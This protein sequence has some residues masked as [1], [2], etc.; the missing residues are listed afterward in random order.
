MPGGGTVEVRE[1]GD[2]GALST[3]AILDD[4]E[5]AAL[6]NYSVEYAQYVEFPTAYSGSPPPFEPIFDWVDRKWNDLGSGIKTDDDGEEMTKEEVARR[7]QF[8]I[9]KNGTDGVY[10]GSR[11]VEKGEANAPSVLASFE[12]SGDPEANQKALA[13][14]ANG[15]FRESQRII[16]EEA[17]DTGNLLQSGS[18]E[19]FESA[20]DLPESGEQ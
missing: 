14:V 10:F 12:G 18:I 20:D 19:W 11:A 1:E 2:K 6:I 13:E 16:R 5:G 17:V 7:V 9:A 4:M 15:I 3:E 8:G